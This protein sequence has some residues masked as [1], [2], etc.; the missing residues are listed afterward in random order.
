VGSGGEKTRIISVS[1]SCVSRNM[2]LQPPGFLNFTNSV[3]S[4]R[5]H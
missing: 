1:I 2:Q 4:G 5:F 3:K